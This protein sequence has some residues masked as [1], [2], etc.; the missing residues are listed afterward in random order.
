MRN[1]S[2]ILVKKVEL[3]P[4]MKRIMKQHLFKNHTQR[5][6]IHRQDTITERRTSTKKSQNLMRPIRIANPHRKSRKAAKHLSHKYMGASAYLSQHHSPLKTSSFFRR[7]ELYSRWGLMRV[8]Q[9]YP[10]IHM[11]SINRVVFQSSRILLCDNQVVSRSDRTQ[12]RLRTIQYIPLKS[13][14]YQNHTCP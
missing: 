3:K 6:K 9:R 8:N 12:N 11:R 5:L 1:Q 2:K 13:R 4:T 7:I 10:I 14:R